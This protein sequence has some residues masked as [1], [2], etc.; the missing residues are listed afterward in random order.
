MILKKLDN[1]SPP[2]TLFYNEYES[3][4]SIISGI[5]TI[6]YYLILIGFAGYFSLN[7]IQKKTLKYFTLIVL[8]KRQE[9]LQLILLL[10]FIL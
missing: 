9:H 7:I 8:K 4:S 10:Y 5:L 3:H 6:F 1:L 2:I